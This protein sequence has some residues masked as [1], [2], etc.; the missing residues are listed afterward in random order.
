MKLNKVHFNRLLVEK[1]IS[2]KELSKNCGLSYPTILAL[3]N[4]KTAISPKTARKLLDYFDVEYDY[5]FGF[6]D[7]K[8]VSE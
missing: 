5:L 1:G 7:L 3:N 6:N 2:K 4:D 8:E